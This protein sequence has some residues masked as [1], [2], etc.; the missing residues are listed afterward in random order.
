VNAPF[1]DGDSR[2]R[3]HRYMGT[4]VVE[5]TGSE[6]AIGAFLRAHRENIPRDSALLGSWTR[7]PGRCGRRVTQEEVA[8]AVGVSRN[9]Y[10]RLESGERRASLKLLDRLA[11]ALD[12]SPEERA[13]LLLLAI[14]ELRD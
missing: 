5:S 10:R 9:W 8:K 11:D 4:I 2:F 14:P 7:P 12:F 3:Y 13:E 1:T 6:G